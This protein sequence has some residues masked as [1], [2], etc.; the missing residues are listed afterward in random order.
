M[1]FPKF[2]KKGWFLLIVH[3]LKTRFWNSLIFFPDFPK[4]GHPDF[5]N[6][7]NH[8]WY[9]RLVLAPNTWWNSICYIYIEIKF[10]LLIKIIIIKFSEKIY[11]LEGLYETICSSR[12][13]ILLK[14]YLRQFGEGVSVHL[15]QRD[16]TFAIGEM[17][18]LM[19][20]PV[21]SSLYYVHPCTVSVSI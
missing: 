19:C 20:I 3:D 1:R 15:R 6:M 11:A 14:I 17:R 18:R 5:T 16:S 2:L 9:I 10:I 8:I 13:W 12:I 21:M 4:A 7:A